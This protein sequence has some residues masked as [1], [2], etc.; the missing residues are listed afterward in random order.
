[1]NAEIAVTVDNVILC[2]SK[3]RFKIVLIKRKNDPF[4]GEWA[5]PGG[6]VEENEDLPDAAKRELKEETGLVV[7][8][9]EQ[10][11]TFGKPNRDP[12]GRMISIVYLSLIDSEENLKGDSDAA[13]AKWFSIDD[14]PKLAFDHDEIIKTAYDYL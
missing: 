2:K 11:G 8:N 10:I 3:D 14:L 6:F 1:M 5:L 12:R 13:D 7:K 4:K 9:N